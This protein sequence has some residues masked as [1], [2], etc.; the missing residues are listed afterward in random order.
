MP[1]SRRMLGTAGRIAVFDAAGR[2][3][4]DGVEGTRVV[5]QHHQVRQ[6]GGC[7][8]GKRLL[9]A[10]H[11]FGGRLVG[12]GD[13]QRTHRLFDLGEKLLRVRLPAATIPPGSR[14]R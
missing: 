9:R 8:A 13:A 6:L 14:P 1:P 7:R 11:G 2:I 10:H 12:A 3:G 4:F 5:P